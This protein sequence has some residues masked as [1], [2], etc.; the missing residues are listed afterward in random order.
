[1]KNRILHS[2]ILVFLC[3][4]STSGIAQ[5]FSERGLFPPQTSVQVLDNIHDGK[6]MVMLVPQFV[7]I[8]Q[9]RIEIDRRIKYRHWISYA[10]HY[11]QN[12]S[13][14]QTHWGAGLGAT[15]KWFIAP[16]SPIYIGGGLQFTHH[17]LENWAFDDLSRSRIWLY[18]TDITQ[19][20]INAIAGQYIR[21][22][23][24]VY[25]DIYV[26]LGYRFSTTTT[27][28]GKPHEFYNGFFNLGYQGVM[29]VFG[30]RVG[31]M[32]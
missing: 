27:S 29:F 13:E 15:Y 24:R 11:V 23:P 2:I 18:K 12:N 21:F 28:D 30:L 22:F 25:G 9:I 6:T 5:P 17:A 8:D 1:M 20:G 7:L 32:L 26:G 10:P 19:Y 16:E 31:I 4:P 3:L 14:F